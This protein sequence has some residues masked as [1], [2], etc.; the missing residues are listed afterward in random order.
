MRTGERPAMPGETG[1][2]ACIT[3]EYY[4]D[5]ASVLFIRRLGSLQF[6]D[7]EHRDSVEKMGLDMCAG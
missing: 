5:Y 6:S 2:A 4:Y 1:F 3:V 7:N